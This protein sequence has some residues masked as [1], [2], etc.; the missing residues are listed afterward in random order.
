MA[1][2]KRKMMQKYAQFTNL[3]N[4]ETMK[5]RKF[6]KSMELGPK[7]LVAKKRPGQ[8]LPNRRSLQPIQLFSKRKI[9]YTSSEREGRNIMDDSY[10]LVLVRNKILS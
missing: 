8:L 9:N 7:Y 3:V 6:E 1:I 5:P 10:K 2:E 4:R